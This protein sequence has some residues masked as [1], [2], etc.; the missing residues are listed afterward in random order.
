MTAGSSPLSRGILRVDGTHPV[1]QR[2]IPA[3][4]GNTLDCGADMI[5]TGD[6]PR[7][8]GEYNGAWRVSNGKAGSSPLSRGILVLDPVGVHQLG[9]IPALAG[10]TSFWLIG[11]FSLRDHP[12]SRGEYAETAKHPGR[13]WGSSPLSR[14]ILHLSVG[15]AYSTRIIPALAGNT[16]PRRGSS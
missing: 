9:I 14:G 6:H 4:A 5:E 12:R 8:R 15:Y 1:R 2:I 3:L 16:M 10:N 11:A 7:S 13:H